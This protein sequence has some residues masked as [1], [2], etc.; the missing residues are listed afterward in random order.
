M[1]VVE[2]SIAYLDQPPAAVSAAARSALERFSPRWSASTDPGVLVP[3]ESWLDVHQA[4]MAAGFDFLVDHTA[5]DYPARRPRFT[6]VT[7][8]MSLSTQERL[9]VKTRVDEGASVAS[10]TGLW[11][12][13]D[14]AERETYDMFGI[15]FTGHPDL[16]RIYMP[17]E[18]EGWPG[19]RDFPLHGHLR[20]R[21]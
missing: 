17:E 8:L 9:I 1:D 2:S 3:R 6:V 5:V 21:D 7:V 12:S 18:Y 16:T 10:L 4:L 13:A 15:P 11:K 20:F 14:W 19:R